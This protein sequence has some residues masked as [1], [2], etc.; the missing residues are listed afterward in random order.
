MGPAGETP[1]EGTDNFTNTWSITTSNTMKVWDRSLGTYEISGACQS[2]GAFTDKDG[3]EI[4]TTYERNTT[5][6]IETLVAGLESLRSS[7][8]P[9][10]GPF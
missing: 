9:A 5:A 10:N 8:G 1:E 4:T 6:G 2:A 7:L 3:D